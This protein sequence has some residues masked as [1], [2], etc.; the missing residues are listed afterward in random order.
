MALILRLK[1]VSFFFIYKFGENF[2]SLLLFQSRVKRKNVWL[3]PDLIAQLWLSQKL[4][5]GGKHS[6]SCWPQ[7]QMFPCPEWT[8][9]PPACSSNGSNSDPHEYF[10]FTGL[11]KSRSPAAASLRPTNSWRGSISTSPSGRHMPPRAPRPECGVMRAILRSV[12]RGQSCWVGWKSSAA[13]HWCLTDPCVRHSNHFMTLNPLWSPARYVSA[14]L[15]SSERTPT[16]KRC[17]KGLFFHSETDSLNPCLS[18]PISWGQGESQ[19]QW[20]PHGVK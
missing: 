15:C 13:L 14:A 10:G 6:E 16:L 8:A 1:G 9:G 2:P 19:S 11:W 4:N 17:Q 12:P 3:P 7:I 18:F 5:W 20:A